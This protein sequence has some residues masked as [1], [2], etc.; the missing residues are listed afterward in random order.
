VLCGPP[1]GATPTTQQEHILKNI[2][3]TVVWASDPQDDATWRAVT[4]WAK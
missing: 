3:A 2:L 4:D 1:S